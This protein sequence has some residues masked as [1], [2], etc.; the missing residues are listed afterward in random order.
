M[1]QPFPRDDDRRP[2]GIESD[3]PR[4]KSTVLTIAAVVLIGVGVLLTLL[5]VPWWITVLF[6]AIVLF[7]IAFTT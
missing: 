6:V 5:G 3:S 2:Q 4:R 7:L 1:T